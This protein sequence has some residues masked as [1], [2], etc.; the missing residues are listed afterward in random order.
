MTYPALKIL[1]LVV[2]LQALS[3]IVTA[4]T[5]G[6]SSFDKVWSYATLYENEDNRFIQKFALSGRLQPDSAWF[7]ADQGEYTDYFLWRRF[8]FGFKSDIFRQWVLHI[9]GEFDLNESLGDAYT[10]L[11]DAYVGWSPKK[12]LNLKV[13]KQTAGFTLDGATSSRKLLTMERN[14]LTNNLWFIREYFTGISAKG[15]VD[16]SWSYKIG[17]FSSDGSEELSRL[18]AGYFALLS[19]GYGFIK[20]PKLDLGQIRVDYVYNQ[21]DINAGTSD[22]SQ[23]LSLV[24]KWETGP[25]GLW[26]DLSAGKGYAEQSDVWG[27]VLMPFHNFNLRTQVVLRYTYLSSAG[28][29]GLRL[30]RYESEIVDGRGNE[31]NEV[32]AGLNVYF[33]GHKFKWQTGLQYASMKDDADD[34]GEY[35]GWGLSTGLRFYW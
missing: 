25:W 11:T 22:F 9:E 6:E 32:Y 13:L 16:E 8:R 12:N 29:N 14:D 24:T 7:D 18:E 26:T 20:S 27:V 2:G 28:D 15:E 17:I 5:T 3:L 1:A 4:Q 34:G 31:Y 30:P 21:E 33:Y 10:R 35:K 19:L 23:I